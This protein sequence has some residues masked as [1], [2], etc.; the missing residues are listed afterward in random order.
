MTAFYPNRRNFSGGVIG[1]SMLG[2]TD[3]PAYTHGL[4]T[5]VNWRVE[6][7]GGL[8]YRRGSTRIDTFSEDEARVF[9]FSRS[10][11]EDVVVL[12]TENEVTMYTEEGGVSG[13]ISPNL[14]VNPDFYDGL[15]GWDD[16]SGNAFYKPLATK[17]QEGGSIKFRNNLANQ[18]SGSGLYQPAGTVVPDIGQQV[19]TPDVGLGHNLS[20]TVNTLGAGPNG[21]SE[22]RNVEIT[23]QV[24]DTAGGPIIATT[25][26]DL[27]SSPIGERNELSL[28]FVDNGTGTFYVEVFCGSPNPAPATTG[29]EFL[30]SDIDVR[31]SAAVVPI[32]FVSPWTSTQLNDIQVAMDTATGTMY[33][34]HENV[35]PQYLEFIEPSIWN[36]GPIVFTNAPTSWTGTNWPA[37]PAIFQGRLWL[38]RTP[39]DQ[40]TLWGSVTASYT[41]FDMTLGTPAQALEFE[42]ATNGV[43]QWIDAQK[44]MIIGT[45]LSEWVLSAQLGIVT[46]EDFKFSVESSH[47]SSSVQPT[48]ASEQI[49][50]VNSSQ[51]RV[52]AM[53][54]WENIRG[55]QSADVSYIN[56]EILV[57][58]IRR[59]VYARDPSYLLQ[60]V[61]YDGSMAVCTYD[62]QLKMSSWVKWGTQG[63]YLDVTVT[64]DNEG[65]STWYAVRGVGGTHLEYAKE[66]LSDVYLDSYV[67]ETMKTGGPGNYIDGLPYL[68]GETVSVVGTRIINIVD[69]TSYIDSNFEVQNY[70]GE[71]EVTSGRIDLPDTTY[72]TRYYIGYKYNASA[73]PTGL[74]AGNQAGTGEGTKRNSN[75]VF[76]RMVQS[77]LP[78]VDG[79]IPDYLNSDVLFGGTEEAGDLV[80]SGDTEVRLT[81]WNTQGSYTITY[82]TPLRC[83]ILSLFGKS[84]SYST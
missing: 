33:F 82:D 44:Q 26:T 3:S 66:Q 13:A 54:D 65:S 79:V 1:N 68:D 41:N 8:T 42:L 10:R 47:G 83:S 14:L 43:I 19:V 36:F 18:F 5:G 38:G 21:N 20:L 62:R 31:A 76:L 51:T 53:N 4:I 11:G 59:M 9:T 60:C 78:Q 39:S 58:R 81:G 34:C 22:P 17:V 70:I 30:I 63:D 48:H 24:R 49:V 64:N 69:P 71:Y 16:N 75:R 50:Y 52:W 46:F 7:Q 37:C 57:P 2:R 27:S 32:T 56:P 35:A 29:G 67:E 15:E 61:M 12:V 25:T 45:D 80:V 74:D 73:V 77:G 72:T 28:A 84:S 40:S 55:W 6:P 23:L